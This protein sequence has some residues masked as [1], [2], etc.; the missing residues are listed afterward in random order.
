MI[1]V[2]TTSNRVIFDISPGDIGAGLRLIMMFEPIIIFTHESS[3]PLETAPVSETAT[4]TGRYRR[5]AG[6]LTNTSPALGI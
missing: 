3:T 6:K 4:F 5:K 2:D 1:T